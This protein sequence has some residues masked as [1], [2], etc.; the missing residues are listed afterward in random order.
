MLVSLL[1]ATLLQIPGPAALVTGPVAGPVD[2]V[3]HGGRV[4]TMLEPE[5]AAPP[6]AVAIASGRVVCVGDDRRVLALAG[7]DT[8]IID[9]GGRA[10]VP[11]LV[12]GHAH[13]YG[14]GK[15]LAEI[16]VRG[17]PDADACAAR[18]A[19]AA[20]EQ[21]QGWLQGRG[22]DQNLWP[23]RAWPTREQLDRVVADRPVMLRRVGGHAAWVNSRALALAGITAATPDPD[24]GAILRDRDGEP[25][26]ILV[27]NAADLVRAVIPPPPPAEVERRIRLAMPHCNALGLTAIHEM[28]AT[29]DRVEIYRRLADQGELS[30]RVIVFL[31]DDPETLDRGLAAGPYTSADRMLLVRGVKLYADGALGSRGALLLADYSDQPGSRGLQVTS[32]EHLEDA[33][34]RAVDAGFQVATHA[35]GDGANRLMLDIYADVLGGAAA[36]RRW[37]IEHAQIVAP[38][39]IP[40]FGELGV[41]ASMQPVHCTSDMD[42]VPLR[43]GPDRLAGA[44]AWRS[45]LATGA[46]LSFGSDAPVESAAPVPGLFAACTRTH[47]DHTPPGGW[48]PSEILSEREALRAFT[49]GPAYAAGLDEDLGVIAPGRLADITVLDADPTGIPAPDLLTVAPWLTLVGGRVVWQADPF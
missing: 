44:Y 48:R 22:W 40:R 18:V 24:G 29:W 12:D 33:C 15:A 30:L 20:S 17:L 1:L 31:E 42:W 35:I 49:L 25:S 14:I 46:V 43:L 47:P 37:R 45:L 11:G 9:L 13:L 3:L 27:D 32:R 2:L 28:G 38:A 19:E 41:I 16:D 21:P 23:D 26:G 34:R 10:A 5:P 4:V 6:T 36:D 8:R 7:P 39:D